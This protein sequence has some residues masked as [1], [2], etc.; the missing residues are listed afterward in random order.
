MYVAESCLLTRIVHVCAVHV[1]IAMKRRQKEIR[2][3]EAE[4]E[5]YKSET[6]TLQAKLI[7]A[8]KI[9]VRALCVVTIAC[10]FWGL[11]SCLKLKVF[12]WRTSL[13]I[14]GAGTQLTPCQGKTK[15]YQAVT[16]WY[17]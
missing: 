5:R 12:P 17:V 13:F 11:P 9:L 7:E 3:A 1:A 2:E 14:P 4:L 15:G 16:R 8:E 10:M 6:D